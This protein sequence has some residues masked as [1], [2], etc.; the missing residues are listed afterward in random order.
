M[1]CLVRKSITLITNALVAIALLPGCDVFTD[2]A[3]RL[4]YDMESAAK[5]LRNHGDKY[6]LHHE[7]PSKQGECEGPYT[8]Q[9]DKVGALIIWCKDKT[10]AVVSSPGTIYHRR[11]VQT[12]ET[13]YLEKDAGETLVIELE[14]RGDKA[15][16]VKVH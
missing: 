11:F 3:T 4:A 15:V 12:P 2:A 9:L 13:Y 8:V 5:K 14:R 1:T 7:T 6:I 16:I 10:G